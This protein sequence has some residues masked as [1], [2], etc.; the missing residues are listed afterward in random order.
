MAGGWSVTKQILE[1]VR[2]K[3]ICEIGVDKA[4]H[5]RLLA[6]LSGEIGAEL[7]LV[8]PAMP[9]LG[10]I[11]ALAHVHVHKERSSEFLKRGIPVDFYIIDGDHNYETVTAELLGAEENAGNGNLPLFMLLNDTTWPFARRDSS[12]N[13]AALPPELAEE[14][15]DGKMLSMVHGELSDH[16]GLPDVGLFQYR[17]HQ[18]GEKN[19]VLTAVEDWLRPRAE[20]W[21]CANFPIYYGYCFLWRPAASEPHVSAAVAN[22]LQSLERVREMIALYETNR[23]ALVEWYFEGIKRLNE[24]KVHKNRKRYELSQIERELQRHRLLVDETQKKLE[25]T[26]QKLN[27]MRGKL[28]SSRYLLVR[29][30]KSIF[31]RH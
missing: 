29:L 2:P 15:V 10:A 13:P 27:K 31:R 7:H 16:L 12:Y 26:Q 17:R 18:G 11:G 19:G 8:D 3:K 25:E 22:L 24:Y 30:I 4:T 21:K 28:N 1:I 5:T 14:F 23:I 9:S 6:E 20:S